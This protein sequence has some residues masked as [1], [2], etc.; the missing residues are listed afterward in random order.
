MVRWHVGDHPRA[1][2]VASLQHPELHRHVG[3]GNVV[4]E[5]GVSFLAGGCV[6]AVTWCVFSV[7]L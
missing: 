1:L 5:V 6:V 4:I 3:T 2:A 7:T